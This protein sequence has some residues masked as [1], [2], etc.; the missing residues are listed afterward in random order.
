MAFSDP[1]TVIIDGESKALPRISVGQNSSVYSEPDGDLKLTI[2]HN[3]AKRTRRTVRLDDA[4][5][6]PDAFTAANL[7]HSMSAYLVVDTPKDGYTIAEAAVVVNALIDYLA[8]NSD[9]AV[10][11]L[12]G[13]EN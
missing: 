7:R 1:Q 3:Y 11:K 9:V 5:V 6:A 4:K 8:A 2:S 10:T 13:G 12:L